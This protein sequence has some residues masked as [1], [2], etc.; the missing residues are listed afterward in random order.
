MAHHTKGLNPT[1]D[2][3]ATEIGRKLVDLTKMSERSLQ[4][5]ST[6]VLEVREPRKRV[7]RLG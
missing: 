6:T 3:D 7:G 1:E 4:E 2:V 5:S